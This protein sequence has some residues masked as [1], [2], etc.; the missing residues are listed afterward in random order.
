MCGTF[1][2]LGRPLLAVAELCFEIPV[3]Y[4]IGPRPEFLGGDAG[5]AS[6]LEVADVGN[7]SW[8]GIRSQ[9]KRPATRIKL[10]HIGKG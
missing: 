9:S 7:V 10:S 3:N 4:D 1:A 8:F 6:G 5:D 2:Y